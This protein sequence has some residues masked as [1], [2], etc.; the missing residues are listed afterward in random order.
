MRIC[1]RQDKLASEHAGFVSAGAV[2]EAHLFH[3]SLPGYAPTPLCDLV[4]LARDLGLGQVL[5]KDE[6][7]RLG[8]NAFKGLGG[9]YAIAKHFCRRFGLDMGSGTFAELRNGPHAEE[10][11]ATTFVTA[12]DGNHG[13]GVAWT[14][15]LLGCNAV[16]YLPEG[17][18]R[19]RVDAI[20]ELGAEAQ[21]TDMNYDDA[22]RLAA[23]MA[24]E[25]G[26][27]LV[28]DT[29][30][31]G[32][33]VIPADIMRGYTTLAWEAGEQVRQNGWDVP[34]H[35]FVQAG[36]GS[37]A[38]ALSGYFASL[39]GERRPKIVVVEPSGA[40]CLFRTADAD[41]G[42]LHYVT[43]KLDSIMA[44]LCCGEPCILGWRIL[45]DLACAFISCEDSYAVDGMRLLA[46]PIGG[47][48]PIESG[49]SGAV[50]AGVLAALMRDPRLSDARDRLGLDANSRVLLVNTE[51]NTG[52]YDLP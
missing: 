27:V 5:V 38:G 52:G 39:W 36:V 10:V 40:D 16:V 42:E 34:T 1:F 31:D 9:S 13:R 37:M 33:E 18:V 24:R 2:E 28:Q 50:T 22:V 21:V 47:D 11:A 41:D 6:S 49:E 30:W 17:S 3:A 12:T 4:A 29:A 51:G 48:A 46:N 7:K 23:T 25:R 14:A 32:Y 45:S 43:G 26:W 44:G 20:R 19:A 15:K 35:L 8:L